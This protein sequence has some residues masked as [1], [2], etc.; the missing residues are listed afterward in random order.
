MKTLRIIVLITCPV[1]IL[2]GIWLIRVI[3]H[4]RK[5]KKRLGEDEKE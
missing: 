4:E 2:G 1:L 3:R 5:L